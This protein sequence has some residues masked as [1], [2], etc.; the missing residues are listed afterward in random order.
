MTFKK[1]L[2]WVG[3]W[4]LM[5][6]LFGAGVYFYEGAQKGV[7]FFAGYLIELSLSIDN[8]F[9]FICIFT[10]Y[11][12]PPTYQRRVL[13]YG[14]IGAIIFRLIFIVLGVALVERFTWIL[15]LFGA[16]LV[17][18]GFKMVFGEEE[19]VNPKDS[20]IIKMLKKILPVSE[21]F[22]E[23]KFFVRIN[24]KLLATPL[25]AILFLVETTDIFFAIDSIPAI[26]A[27]SLDPFIIFSSNIFAILGLRSWYFVLEKV[28]SMFRFVKYGVGLILAFTGSKLLL[29]FF[30]IHVPIVISL[31][32]I[33]TLLLGSVVMSWLYN[34]KHDVKEETA[35]QYK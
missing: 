33:V 16:V 8:L 14:I 25:F 23:E 15:Y 22:H 9:L 24:G 30:H 34:K 20:K 19:E 1:A 5:A 26:F 6:L 13:N 31:S 11:G 28:Q 7:E 4:T 3:F 17:V 18:A 10:M 2:G 21:E 29:L 35:V 32:V 12:V 27:V